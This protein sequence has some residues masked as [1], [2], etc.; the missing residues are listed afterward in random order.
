M[1]FKDTLSSLVT[2]KI[3]VESLQTVGGFLVMEDNRSEF[4]REFCAQV[5]HQI[6]AQNYTP[7]GNTDKDAIIDFE[8]PI[9][10]VCYVASVIN[11]ISK[12]N[13]AAKSLMPDWIPFVDAAKVVVDDS[14]MQGPPE[15][16]FGELG[17][18]S[19]N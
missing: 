13:P 9:G 6:T 14:L 19:M 12:I 17:P 2:A 1:N 7:V 15:R 18:E 16:G 10:N 11:D 8:I 4:S 5:V 3:S